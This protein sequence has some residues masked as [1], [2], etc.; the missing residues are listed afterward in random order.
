M[1]LYKTNEELKRLLRLCKVKEYEI[2]KKIDLFSEKLDDESMLSCI[3]AIDKVEIY[4]LPYLNKVVQNKSVE[5]LIKINREK[6]MLG[7]PPKDSY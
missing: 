2:A 1:F 4:S 6:K 5:N 3:E 7:T